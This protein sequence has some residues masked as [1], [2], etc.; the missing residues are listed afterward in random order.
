M[1]KLLSKLKFFLKKNVFYL[2]E[3]T[4]RKKEQLKEE[5]NCC[6]NFI[7]NL[8]KPLL[9]VLMFY[10]IEKFLSKF[11]D[12]QKILNNFD[13]NIYGN[14]LITF[15]SFIGIF[16]G[17]YFTSLNSALS[18]IYSKLPKEFKE[19]FWKRELATI[20]FQKTVNYLVVIVLLLGMHVFKI[21]YK[22]SFFLIIIYT[23]YTLFNCVKLSQKLSEYQN[24]MIFL[25][26]IVVELENEL[27]QIFKGGFGYKDDNFQNYHHQKVNKYLKMIDYLSAYALD[28][29]E[30]KKNEYDELINIMFNLVI[31]Y[32][33]QKSLIPNGSLWFKK[34]NEYKNNLWEIGTR[35]Q[36]EWNWMP[37]ETVNYLWFEEKILE[38]IL[39][40][41]RSGD[42]SYE[43]KKNFVLN[44]K[45]K[46]GKYQNIDCH[47]I[48]LEDYGKFLSIFFGNH[49]IKSVNKNIKNDTIFSFVQN[50]SELNKQLIVGKIN[51]QIKL[52]HNHVQ[53]VS[54]LN[55]PSDNIYACHIPIYLIEVLEKLNKKMT[56]ERKIFRRT[57]TPVNFVNREVFY[58]ILKESDKTIKKSFNMIIEYFFVNIKTLSEQ[59]Q[60]LYSLLL[61]KDFYFIDEQLRLAIDYF[62][63]I[64]ESNKKVYKLEEIQK[65]KFEYSQEI[66]TLEFIKKE[67]EKYLN[68]SIVEIKWDFK[69]KS[70]PDLFSWGVN[71]KQTFFYQ[72]ILNKKIDYNDI[73]MLFKL[74]EKQQKY[75][76]RDYEV[77]YD[78][79]YSQNAKTKRQLKGYYDVFLLLGYY[80]VYSYLLDFKI[81]T[82]KI[83]E[84]LNEI[85]IKNVPQ[86]INLFSKL[87]E[88]AW[89]YEED[90][91]NWENELKKLLKEIIE[92]NPNLKKN[93]DRLL[94]HYKQDTGGTPIINTIVNQFN[95][96]KSYS[97]DRDIFLLEIFLCYFYLEEI[98]LNNLNS[99]KLKEIFNR[100]N[101]NV[102]LRD[103]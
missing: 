26:I 10:L 28:K 63:E 12:Y 74:A 9:I 37:K 6:W 47:E 81:D 39:Q 102:L 86:F 85:K 43:T 88:N 1:V 75:I 59:N 50:C 16:L 92:K 42:V 51:K 31:F 60:N 3:N 87:N 33:A 18:H 52:L 35:G 83:K 57:I 20:Q 4:K 84:T 97:F 7:C 29:E 100:E 99:Y 56:K 14:I 41:F 62:N 80:V 5:I 76:Q 46:I 103:V 34:I 68:K 44:L 55:I 70:I 22:S 49:E 98:D 73:K 64:L 71:K 40:F 89:N 13:D 27:K 93:Q 15:L 67:S 66:T 77:Y 82:S 45:E 69:E 91:V 21:Q 65:F 94:S 11:I 48:Y 53:I 38:K 78:N 19:I 72:S 17:F 90:R 24:P 61:L 2:T 23:I 96:D 95:P 54:E 25:N 30:N 8:N 101:E 79:T 58:K 36:Y 32:G